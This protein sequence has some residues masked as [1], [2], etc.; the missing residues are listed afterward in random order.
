MVF[1][2][3]APF[4]FPVMRALERDTRVTVKGVLTQPDRERGRGREKQSPPVAEFARELDLP[5]FQP[6][7]V[8]EDGL[9]VLSEVGPLDLG[10]VIAYGQILSREV[11]DVTERGFFN[12][13]ASLLPRWRGASPIRHALMAGDSETGV[14]VFRV[15]EDLD[16]GPICVSLATPIRENETY[17]ELYE[18]LSQVNVGALN[19]LISDFESDSLRCRPQTGDAT[20]APRI[21][22]DTGRINWTKNA[23]DVHNLIRAFCPDPGAFSFLNDERIKIYGGEPYPTSTTDREPGEILELSGDEILVATGEGTL[24]ISELQPAGSRR[25]RAE[26]FL[27]GQPDIEAGDRFDLEKTVGN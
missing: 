13:H 11:L 5:L 16:T 27:A 18:R 20:Y 24:G 14:T 7:D 8:N 25:M 9:D 22:T 12:F 3:T 10:I 4:G 23:R 19:V 17:G 21:D 6:E 2:G 26:S 15:E 1:L